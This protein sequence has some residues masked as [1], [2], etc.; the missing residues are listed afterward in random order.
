MNYR[1]FF[2]ILLVPV[3]YS[4]ANIK[5]IS[6]GPK[7]E[8]APQLIAN[9][10]SLPFQKNFNGKQLNFYFDEWIRLENP[11]SAITISPSLEFP[12]KYIL[13][14]K[15]L[16]IQFDDKEQ[17]KPNTSYSIQF[18]EA[19]KDITVGNVQR[20]LRYIF[21]TGDYID[22]LKLSGIVKLAQS[23]LPKDRV[24][25]GLYS[26]LDDTAFQ[27]LKPFYFCFTD[28]SGRFK[29]ENIRPDTYK[30]YALVDK[31]Q[32]YYF[33]QLGEFFAF[34]N[35]PIEI[36]EN[37]EQQV[38]L[39]LSESKPPLF[40]KDK[41]NRNGKLKITFNEKPENYILHTNQ[42]DQIKWTLSADSL[43][44]WNL[45]TNPQELTLSYLN[46]TDTLV[47]SAKSINELP[48]EKSLSMMDRIL[49]PGELPGFKYQDPILDLDLSKISSS[50]SSIIIHGFEK[51][52]LDQRSIRLTGSFSG[53]SEFTI[54]V[55]KAA[56]KVW[57]DFQ[58]KADTFTIRYYDKANL[59][60]LILK[61]D[62]LNTQQAYVIELIESEN[63][64]AKRVL[65]KEFHPTELIF[66]NILPGNYKL[67]LIE[68][69]NQNQHWDPARFDQKVQAEMIK[70]FN[71]PELRA[72]WDIAVTIKP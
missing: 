20:D 1:C 31:N 62:S 14:G 5:G 8:R 72:D 23:N 26:N 57:P 34:M 49:K 40:I 68:D 69:I 41:I 25:V 48:V 3:I 39:F 21:S 15:N 16:V 71:L 35:E 24:L 59:S 7:D 50:D 54:Y 13:K 37:K 11:Q 36:K 17:L 66:P 53:K 47:L 6:G 60:R 22:S 32:N 51:D 44:I 29:L 18:G 45:S 65:N 46:Q 9:K 55:Q 4:C 42:P 61:L 52:S 27:K 58:S 33:D 63:V 70:I 28:T 30:L 12:P 56:F 19:I 10:S 38:E 67:R 43:L 2:L 64:V